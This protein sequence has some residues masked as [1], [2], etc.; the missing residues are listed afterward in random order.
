MK[1]AY[2]MIGLFCITGSL[3]CICGII[4]HSMGLAIPQN[5][6]VQLERAGAYVLSGGLLAFLMVYRPELKKPAS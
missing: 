1:I 4:G 6:S 3:L 2:L 5:T